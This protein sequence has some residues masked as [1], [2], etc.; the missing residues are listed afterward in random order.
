MSEEFCIWCTGVKEYSESTDPRN[1]QAIYCINCPNGHHYCLSKN[2]YQNMV[3][4]GDFR[5][6]KIDLAQ[7]EEYCKKN[8]ESATK[9]MLIIGRDFHI[10]YS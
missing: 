2:L 5:V 10:V 6:K 9:N 1:N 4:L 7:Y 3:Q 8:A